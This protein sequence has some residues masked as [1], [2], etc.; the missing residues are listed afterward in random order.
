MST[1][2]EQQ[3]E[4]LVLDNDGQPGEAGEATGGAAA[5]SSSAPS[6]S[7]KLPDFW[8]ADPEMWFRQAESA[9]RR[10]QVRDSLTKYD[11]VLTKLPEAVIASVR[12]L[13]RSVDDSSTDAY[14]RLR[15][16]LLSSFGQSKWHQ[17]NKLIDHQN[18]G[19]GARRPSTLMDQMLTLLPAGEKP[20]LLFTGLFLKRLYR[21]HLA[22]RDFTS[23]RQMAEY[24]D[25]LWDARGGEGHVLAAIGNQQQQRGRSPGRYNNN[26][27]RGRSAGRVGR[28]GSRSSSRS[29]GFRR[30][31]QTPGPAEVC[32][33]HQE[34]G[35]DA[36][37]CKSPCSFVGNVLAAGGN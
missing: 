33:Y 16:R 21:E 8:T 11:H 19:L 6:T 14:E 13:V 36:R 24:A 31:Q 29:T 7:V 9:F 32:W 30:R 35:M 27:Q 26:R 4:Q 17:I 15:S 5:N 37:K 28:S 25:V 20:G 34:Y 10:A 2:E 18:L 12:D 23:P 22:A 1:E 3:L